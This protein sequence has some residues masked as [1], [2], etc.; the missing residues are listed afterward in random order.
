MF[1][2]LDVAVAVAVAMAAAAAVQC[3]K[4]MLFD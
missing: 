2:L 3:F 1:M 4:K